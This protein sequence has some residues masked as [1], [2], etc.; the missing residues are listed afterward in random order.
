METTELIGQLPRELT[1]AATLMRDFPAPWCIGGGW[2]LD[3]FLGRLTRAHSDV[4]L[5]LLREDQARLHEHLAG[6]QLRKVV[7][8]VLTSW[9]ATEWLASPV[10]EVHAQSPDD[11]NI[12]LEFL[13]NERVGDQWVFR[14]DPTVRCPARQVI[15]ASSA[16]LPVLCPAVV[17]LYK[18]KQPRAVDE[19]DFRAVRDH[20]APERREWIRAALE[21]THPGHP[22]LDQR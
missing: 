21:H 10:H 12:T 8:G 7:N 1:T 14:R 2:A 5:A 20:L 3:L 9:P 4:D 19:L 17:L 11:P 16:G 15:A 18:A 13:L 22:W 6:W